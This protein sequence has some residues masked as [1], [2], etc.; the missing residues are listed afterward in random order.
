MRSERTQVA[1]R[2]DGDRK[3]LVDIAWALNMT[4]AGNIKKAVMGE[5]VGTLIHS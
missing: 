3:P 4:V 1:R 5:T 2:L